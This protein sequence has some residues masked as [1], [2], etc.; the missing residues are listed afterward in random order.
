MDL[1]P[2]LM[3]EHRDHHNKNQPEGDN[4]SIPQAWGKTPPNTGRKRESRALLARSVPSP[5][6]SVHMRKIFQN[7]STSLHSTGHVLGSPSLRRANS[8][9]GQKPDIHCTNTNKIPGRPSEDNHFSFTDQLPSP[10]LLHPVVS[11][12]GSRWTMVP[13]AD[14]PISSG[15]HSPSFPNRRITPELSNSQY[16]NRSKPKRVPLPPYQKKS[17]QMSLD[18]AKLAQRF[19]DTSISD[20]QSW[21]D[22]LY[23]EPS[24]NMHEYDDFPSISK[25]KKEEAVLG[26]NF[27]ESQLATGHH[28]TSLLKSDKE[29]MSP[30]PSNCGARFPNQHSSLP[31]KGSDIALSMEASPSAS[32][33]AHRSKFNPSTP[34]LVR[35]PHKCYT[36]PRSQRRGQISPT[37]PRSHFMLPP[38]RKKIRSSS[39]SLPQRSP[40]AYG[41]APPFEVAEDE[42]H[43]FPEQRP[44]TSYQE[45]MVLLPGLSDLSPHVTPFRK[46]KGPK[47]PR[48]P[49]YYDEDLLQDT[50][51]EGKKGPLRNHQG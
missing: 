48:C 19:Q 39:S 26:Y 34:V 29:N 6:H 45:Q 8:P 46:G 12:N 9:S 2:K 36:S 49:S 23:D 27:P 22:G 44:R 1:H 16:L 42:I 41:R 11:P 21:L 4:A 7:A 17:P 47:R 24:S 31:C 37:L 28:Y 13:M 25:A 30:S 14:E 50:Q 18:E 15:F 51:P 20:V 33:Q 40:P 43:D 10:L 38:R 3:D 32:A 5:S 35:K